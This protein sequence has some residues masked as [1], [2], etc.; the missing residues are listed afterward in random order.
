M[1]EFRAGQSVNFLKFLPDGERLLVS[2]QDRHG[3]QQL[4][5]WNPLHDQCVT[6]AMPLSETPLTP[7]Q[8]A[9]TGENIAYVAWEH[10]LRMFRLDNGAAQLFS[11]KHD[12]EEIAG[13]MDDEFLFATHDLFR[14]RTGEFQL[15]CLDL[16]GQV[17]IWDRDV[18]VFPHLIGVLPDGNLLTGDSKAFRLLDRNTGREIR[19]CPTSG[20]RLLSKMSPDGSIFASASYRSLEVIETATFERLQ[21]LDAS[22]AM[23]GEFRSFALMTDKNQVAVVKTGPAV[24]TIHDLGSM[25]VVDKLNWQIGPLTTIDYSHKTGLTAVGSEMGKVVIWDSV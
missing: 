7:H 21:K 15:C 8:V 4:A 23:S 17:V 1:H 14:S 10:R 18:E 20:A 5:I 22:F 19:S 9:I 13:G 11:S 24:V 16:D 2:T 3:L 25:Q 12:Y 6:A